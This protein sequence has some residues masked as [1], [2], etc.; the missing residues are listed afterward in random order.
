[1]QQLEHAGHFPQAHYAFANGVLTVNVTRSI[2]SVGKHWGSD[3]EGS[4]HRQGQGH[5]RRVNAVVAALRQAP[6]ES[7]RCITVRCRNGA[8]KP[9]WAFTKVVRLKRDGP[10]RLV[11]V[12]ET[13]ALRDAPRF[14]RTDARHWES[15]RVIETWRYRWAAEIFHAF[16]TQVPGLE[17][18]Q[19]RK[20]EAVTRHFRLRCVAQSLLQGTSASGAKTERCAFAKGATTLG[21]RARTIVRE[22]RHG[23]LQCAAQLLAQG[24]SCEAVLELLM[25]A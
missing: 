22:V 23:L 17:A 10:Q 25:P 13:A 24:R 8:T 20:A 9:F 1:M 12:H 7:L 14:L 15:G 5:W 19:V 11:I 21:Q 2:A 4:R 6:P 16:G 3:I 18:A